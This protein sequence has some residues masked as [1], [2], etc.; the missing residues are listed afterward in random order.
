MTAT[1]RHPAAPSA[2]SGAD[3]RLSMKGAFSVRIRC[4][5]SVW[6]SMLSTNHPAWNVPAK[7]AW[8]AVS[9]VP[10]DP[11]ATAGQTQKKSAAKVRMSK[12]ELSGPK[13]T[14]KSRTEPVSHLQG[15]A[16]ASS[17]TLSQGIAVQV[18]S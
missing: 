9:S 10:Q 2:R 12:T 14:M 3:A 17:S 13:Q 18:R 1:I 8:P 16:T 6:V 11:P 15:R 4:T 7:S 5:A